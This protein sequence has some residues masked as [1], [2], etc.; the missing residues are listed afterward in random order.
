M[1]PAQSVIAAMITP[2]LLIL[3]SASLVA[4]ALVRL[5]RAV[6]RARA[7]IATIGSSERAGCDGTTTH[8]RLA[9]NGARCSRNDR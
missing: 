6:D 2:A 9:T 1:S 3:G 7:V 4:T 8:A 5:A